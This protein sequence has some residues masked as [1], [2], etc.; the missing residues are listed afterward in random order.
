VIIPLD[1]LLK[2]NGNRYIFTKAAMKAVDKIEN[3][4]DYPEDN[5]NWKVVP[6]ILKLTL[7]E[8]VKFDYHESEEAMNEETDT[9]E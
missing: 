4:K 9:E 5:I 3:I 6:N 2:Y 1:K 8:D 7:D